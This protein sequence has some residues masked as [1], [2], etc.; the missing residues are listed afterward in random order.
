MAITLADALIRRTPLGALG[1]PG[2]A[3]VQRAAEIVSA[4]LGW[5]AERQREECAAVRRFYGSAIIE[6]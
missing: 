6:T 1:Y 5:S 2:D 3:V 4:E